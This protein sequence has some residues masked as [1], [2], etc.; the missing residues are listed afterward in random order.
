[1]KKI[2]ENLKNIVYTADI[3]ALAYLPPVIAVG[4]L[5][6]IAVVSKE[7]FHRNIAPG[8]NYFAIA[9]ACF[10]ASL[11]G[12]AQ[13]VRRESPGFYFGKTIKGKIPVFVGILTVVICWGAGILMLYF[14]IS[15]GK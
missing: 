9:C 1:M 14:A 11:S 2:I 6:S 10:F 12:F 3:F 4:L 8:Y 13:I 5:I 7:I 15:N